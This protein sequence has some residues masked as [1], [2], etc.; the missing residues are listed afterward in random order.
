VGDDDGEAVG[1]ERGNV[2]VGLERRDGFV[3]KGYITGYRRK[4]VTL[5]F[6]GKNKACISLSRKRR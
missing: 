1:Q 6:W 2:I 5:L 4:V 3:H